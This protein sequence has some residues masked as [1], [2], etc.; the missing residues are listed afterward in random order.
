[1]RRGCVLII[2]SLLLS[3]CF[4]YQRRPALPLQVR[5]ESL[6]DFQVF[7]PLGSAAPESACI[8]RRA[9]FVLSG[10]SG[11]TLFFSSMHVLRQ[12][13]GAPPCGHSG[14]G[15]VVVS[16]YPDLR[17]P[18]LKLNGALTWAAITWGASNAIVVLW[19]MMYRGW[20]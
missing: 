20:L 18:Q 14:P 9:D 10:I 1:M 6:T 13:Q 12:P 4:T 2:G 5:L 11:D 16:D 15:R 19:A 8:L 3:G 17:S 7:P